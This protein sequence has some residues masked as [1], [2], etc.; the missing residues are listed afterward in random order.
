V[1]ICKQ[2]FMQFCSTCFFDQDANLE[3]THSG[4]ETQIT[5]IKTL[6]RS[7]KLQLS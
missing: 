7:H 3:H 1:A 2:C 6:I 4:K 5:E